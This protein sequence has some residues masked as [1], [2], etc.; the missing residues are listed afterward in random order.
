MQ[1]GFGNYWKNAGEWTKANF[2]GIILRE[3]LLPKIMHGLLDIL[4]NDFFRFS[5]CGNNQSALVAASKQTKIFLDYA[6]H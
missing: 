5:I 2:N 4:N 6:N 1:S 3:Q